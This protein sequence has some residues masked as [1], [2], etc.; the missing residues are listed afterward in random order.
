MMKTRIFLL[1]GVFAPLV[2]VLT[3]LLGGILRSNYS[4]ISQF[5]SELIAAGAPNK[6]I[7]DPLFAL[8]NILTIA[9]GIGLVQFI[10]GTNEQKGRITGFIGAFILM[11]EGVFG[12]VTVFFPQDPVG[13]L[14]TSTGTMHIVLA[15]LSS[16][17]TMLSMLFIG[18][19]FRHQS[20]WGKTAL[21]SFVSLGIVLVFGGLAAYTG[22]NRSP[23]LG[24]MERI[25]IG[26]FLQWLFFVGL[27]LYSAQAM[28]GAPTQN[29]VLN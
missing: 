26:G 10:R 19:W 20:G 22:A 14:L 3:V 2:Y 5:V 25:T 18:L 23:I 27:Q 16:L 6:N 24:I 17:T 28:I 13:A 11:L 7:L 4:H 29:T 9:F 21:Y 1:C 15:G 8:Y 12:F